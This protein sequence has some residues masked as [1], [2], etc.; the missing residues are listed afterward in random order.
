LSRTVFRLR[1]RLSCDRNYSVAGP[2][3]RC[4]HRSRPAPQLQDEAGVLPFCSSHWNHKRPQ[5]YFPLFTQDPCQ[6][7]KVVPISLGKLGAPLA[8]HRVA[9][10][11]PLVLHL[12]R[13]RA[14]ALLRRRPSA[15]GESPAS[16]RPRNLHNSGSR[17]ASRPSP[18]AANNPPTACGFHPRRRSAARRTL[19]AAWPARG[20]G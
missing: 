12:P 14:L 1:R 3:R 20:T 4:Q 15:R 19:P 10:A 2:S 16:R 13:L 18:G 7:V 11:A 6:H 9:P 17:A 5:N 8:R